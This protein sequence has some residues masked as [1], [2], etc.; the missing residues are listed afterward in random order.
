M[1][2]GWCSQ[3]VGLGKQLQVWTQGDSVPPLVLGALS[4]ESSNL[5]KVGEDLSTLPLICDAQG[6]IVPTSFPFQSG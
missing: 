1:D 6:H 3:R 4:P 2:P 5:P